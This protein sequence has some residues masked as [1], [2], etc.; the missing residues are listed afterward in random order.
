[1]RARDDA[2]QLASMSRNV[3]RNVEKQMGLSEDV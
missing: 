2:E 1:M 3:L